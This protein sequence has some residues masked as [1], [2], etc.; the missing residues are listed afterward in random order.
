MTFTA[1]TFDPIVDALETNAPFVLGAAL[2]G[3][4]ILWGVPKLVG[5]FKKVSK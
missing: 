2:L 1:T 3:M 5:L 4:A